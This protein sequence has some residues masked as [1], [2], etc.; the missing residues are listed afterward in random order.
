MGYLFRAHR[1]VSFPTMEILS[2]QTIQ[3]VYDEIGEGVPP[4]TAWP[5][6]GE[7]IDAADEILATGLFGEVQVRQ[8]DWELEYDSS[9]YIDLLNT[10]SGHV[11]MAPW[12]RE[13]LY[14]EIRRRLAARPDPR[15]HRHWVLR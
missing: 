14:A 12:K 13:R 6:P 10:F 2:F 8:Y 11:A 3:V 1:E 9:S 7:L 5:M 15:L 4:G